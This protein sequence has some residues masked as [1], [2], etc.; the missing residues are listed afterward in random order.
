MFP[1]PALST[2]NLVLVCLVDIY[3]M[4][5]SSLY[6]L[7][8][9][10]AICNLFVSV[11]SLKNV[12]KGCLKE[13]LDLGVFFVKVTSNKLLNISI[14]TVGFWQWAEVLSA[15]AFSAFEDAGLNDIKVC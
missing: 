4:L 11:G 15:D 8:K 6:K 1:F 3:C 5:A 12:F 9:L 2:I 14:S 13:Y 10:W 7:T